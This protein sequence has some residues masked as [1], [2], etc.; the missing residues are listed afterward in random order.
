MELIVDGHGV[1]IIFVEFAVTL[2][3]RKKL[4][5]GDNCLVGV[6][7]DILEKLQEL[8]MAELVDIFVCSSVPIL[9]A[10]AVQTTNQL[11]NNV[12]GFYLSLTNVSF[13]GTVIA[14]EEF[15][16]PEAFGDCQ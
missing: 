10:D 9:S 1:P 6:R 7:D 8:G 11:W 16:V 12:A 4:V 15:W 3:G 14:G 5:L 13:G 2:L